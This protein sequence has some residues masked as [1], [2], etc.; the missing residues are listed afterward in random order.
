VPS[1]DSVSAAAGALRRLESLDKS[2]LLKVMTSTSMAV[3][4]STCRHIQK[5]AGKKASYTTVNNSMV[6]DRLR[7]PP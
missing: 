4:G 3:H 5:R 6:N 1:I 7:K 2:G